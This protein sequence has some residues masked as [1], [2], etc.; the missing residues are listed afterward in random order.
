MPL[1]LTSRP[2]EHR[3]AYCYTCAMSKVEQLEQQ[4]QSLSPQELAELRT[5]F[6]EF[7]WQMWDGQLER[8]IA[9]GKLDQ[10]ADE[11]LR[12]HATGKTTP[13]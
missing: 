13:L 4:I 5:W 10:L 11:A 1:L 3:E 12:D 2:A 9:R 6:H 7:D 8:D